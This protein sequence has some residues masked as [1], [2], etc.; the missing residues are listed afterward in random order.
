M[1]FE[2]R[3]RSPTH[4]A[5]VITDPAEFYANDPQSTDLVSAA[6]IVL[7]TA[8]ASTLGTLYA[9]SLVLGRFPATVRAFAFLGSAVSILSGLFGTVLVWIAVSGTLYLLSATFSDT[10]D[11]RDLV[12][13]VGWGFVPALFSALIGSGAAIY[14]F[15]HLS[16]PAVGE[17]VAAALRSAGDDPLIV[18]ANALGV[19]FTLWQGLIWFFA[20]KHV[21]A[22]ST[23]ETVLTVAGPVGVAVAWSLQTLL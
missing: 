8:V 20:V 10:G 21:R 1:E 22:L 3:R 4:L 12:A 14:V 13:A 19:V 23:R 17:G 5:T 6:L 7:S 15:S 9:M 11:F 18:F 2:T 16:L